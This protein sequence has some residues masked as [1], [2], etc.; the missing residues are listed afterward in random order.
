MWAFFQDIAAVML[1]V[2]Y[3]VGEYLHITL[4]AIR[5]WAYENPEIIYGLGVAAIACGVVALVL[6]AM[7]RNWLR[8]LIRPWYWRLIQ[9]PM[10]RVLGPVR[11]LHRRWSERNM[12][13]RMAKWKAGM[14]AD[15]IGDALLEANI[16]GV[17]SDQEY[18][19]YMEKAG[20]AL[21]LN[22]LVRIK[23]HK[24]AI[25][26]RVTTN[27][28]HKHGPKQPNPAW[29]AKPGVDVVPQYEALGSRFL[30]RH[31]KKTA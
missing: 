25:K 26:H 14:L 28:T 18:R 3:L 17:I 22:D 10:H 6:R 29:G 15:I 20:K 4:N 5:L 30:S 31:L 16:A 7:W 11:R 9:R 21:G 1:G 8:D 27:D 19:K 2:L 12:E 23:N 24:L 13:K